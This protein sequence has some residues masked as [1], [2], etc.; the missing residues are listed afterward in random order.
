MMTRLL[1]ILL[2]AP[3]IAFAQ[4]AQPIRIGVLTDMN[5]VVA[6]SAGRG[7]VIAAQLA[8]EDAGLVLGRPV[9]ILSGDSQIKADIASTIARRWYD[10]DHVDLI[11]DLTNSAVALAVRGI[12]RERGLI[13]IDVGAGTPDLYGK[14]CSPTGFMWAYDAIALS[15]AIG[16]AVVAEGGKKWFFIAADYVFGRQL[17]AAATAVV[18]AQGGEVVGQV[19]VPQNTVDFASAIAQAQASG[20]DVI[21]LAVF[22]DDA[23]NAIKQA[24]EFHLTDGRRIA[25]MLLFDADT[26]GVGLQSMQGTYVASAYYWDQNAQTRAFADRMRARLG[27]PPSMIQSGVYSA[28]HHYLRAVA[29]AGTTEPK[30]VADTMRA[31]PVEDFM[32]HAGV[33]RADGR[34][35]RD[36]VLLRAKTPASSKAEWDIYDV[37]RSIPGAD[38]VPS[39]AE[40]GCP[41]AQAK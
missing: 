31:M 34:V 2:F 8:A 20:A 21:G 26:H 4:P 5:T 27:R 13:D 14:A 39:I 41:Y 29:A 11:T 36:M 37:V 38:L 3:A 18:R 16:S 22:G 12:S 32:T 15:R 25:A 40:A 28:V 23:A 17:A 6:D 9:E 1:A 10:V 7:S 19:L 24:H 35:M 30:K 33:V